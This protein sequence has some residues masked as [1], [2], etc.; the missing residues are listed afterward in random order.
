[1]NKIILTGNLCSDPNLSQTPSGISVCKFSLAV[2]RNYTNTNGERQA[3]FINI[4]TWRSLADNCSKYLHKGSKVALCGQIQTHTYDD[5]N[6]NKR[7]VTEV[8]A[9]DVEF[10]GGNKNEGAE[11]KKT[12]QKTQTESKQVTF[13]ELKPIEDDDFPF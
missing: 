11:S 2:N 7:T 9:D 3:D 12:A 4:V 5:K 1:M 13:G 8:L 6:G 10:I